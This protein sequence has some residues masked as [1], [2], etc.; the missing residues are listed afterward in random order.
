MLPAFGWECV[1]GNLAGALA[2]REAGE[3]ATRVDTGYFYSGTTGFSGGTRASFAAAMALPSFAYRDGA[4]HTVRGADR[5]C[6]MPVRGEM[7]PGV[8]LGG[9]EHLALPRTFPQLREVNVYLGWFGRLSP[10]FSRPLHEVSRVGFAALG[11]P[12]MRELYAAATSR[13]IKGSVG[14]P[15]IAERAR[16]RV[17]VVAIAYDTRGRR[18]GEVSLS[19]VEGYEFTAGIL[20]WAAMRAAAGAIE[21]AGALGPVEAFGIDELEAGC[22]EAGV[23]RTQTSD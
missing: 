8:A 16:S 7:R 17:D 3:A 11:I 21:R 2:L 15:G 14:G 6:T 18:L 19:G 1:L 5:Y 13:L 4:I 10:R 12:G 20:A 22:R 23:T 9:S